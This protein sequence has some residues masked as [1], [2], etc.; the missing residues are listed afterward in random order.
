M[1]AYLLIMLIG[2]LAGVGSVP[3]LRAVAGWLAP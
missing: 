3:A 2:W 1:R